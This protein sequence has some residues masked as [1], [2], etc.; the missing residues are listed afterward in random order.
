MITNRMLGSDVSVRYRD[1][2]G[3][4]QVM[5][6][7]ERPYYFV[8]SSD[9]YLCDAYHKERGHKGVY[10]E[11]LTK[12]IVGHPN[13]IYDFKQAHPHIETWEAN[14]PHV[15]RCLA[16]RL[17]RGE[18]PIKNYEHRIWYL[19]CEWN[20]LTNKM[21]VIVVHDSF[22]GK[23][24][25]WVVDK[26]NELSLRYT[27]PVSETP[28]KV[29]VDEKSMLEHFVAHMDR[30]DPDVI[31]GWYV[32]GA[33][34]K[35]IVER[36]RATGVDAR[37][38]SP[39]RR[40]N[41]TYK[42]W[43]QPI[44]GRVCIDL[45]LGVSKLWELKNGKLPS[46]KLDDVAFEILKEKKIEL[47]DGH[48]TY[49][50]DRPLYVDYCRQDVRLLPKLDNAVNAIGYYIGLQHLVQCDIG[51]TPFITKMFTCLALQ[52]KEFDRRIPTKPQFD[53]E[54]YQG[55][56]VMDV[57]SGVYDEVGILDI[58]AMYHSNASLHNISCD[59]LDDNGDDCGNG[60]C[61][62]KGSKGL[63]VR[64]MDYMTTLRNKFKS[65]M[66]SDPDNYD[67]WDAM[68]FAC[69]SL[70]ASMYGV[71]G[72]SKYGLYHPKIA[73]AITYTSR[74]TLNRLKD[75][76]E[77]AGS[78]VLYGHTDSVFCHISSPYEGEK[79][80]ASINAQMA[81]IEVEFEKWCSRMILVAKNRY[82]G[83]VCWTDGE[84]HDP[85]LYVKGIEMKQSRMPPVMKDSM[86]LVLD[87]IL[88]NKHQNEVTRILED[89][90]SDMVNNKI[91]LD[92][93]SMKGKLEKN[94]SDYKVLSGN[95]AAAA[96]AN[97][98]LGK[99]YG[100][101]SF[102]RV[103]LDTK[104]KYIAFDEPEDIAHVEVGQKIIAKR[105]LIDKVKPYYELVGWSMQPL[106]NALHG[107][108]NM[109]WV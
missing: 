77:N 60:T 36:C 1:E 68:Q 76:A 102:F 88:A 93:V 3:K 80:V 78:K 66:K 35:T 100:K 81:P 32:V 101:G 28:V 29:F 49:Y 45:M 95:A 40:I 12:V 89:T 108:G 41:Y 23:E 85:T 9:S 22:T 98:Y 26:E 52:D 43:A 90:I 15:N 74:A 75:L 57:E 42:D 10:G 19:D 96:W 48:D 72:D 27:H 51:S 94:L 46:Y 70:V 69:K 67:R 53:K 13:D 65:L 61:F 4:R 79:L 30:Q 104:G 103:T 54:D 18:E 84:G 99:G 8:K 86:A 107:L 109:S 11:H 24:Y 92:H 63:L 82:A 83:H 37:R 38:M 7:R 17:N 71:A 106:D 14:I 62:T 21:T 2:D 5:K 87:G 55:A 34:I 56:D 91:H 6:L 16:E 25:V 33:D 20:P 50:T 47:P 73:G 64:Q 39:Y 105:F 31:T 97:E 44:T 59:S 58:K